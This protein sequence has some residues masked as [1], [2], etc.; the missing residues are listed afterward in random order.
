MTK[1]LLG[2]LTPE[3]RELWLKTH[4]PEA[5]IYYE[6]VQGMD[7]TPLEG[8]MY[9]HVELSYAPLEFQMRLSYSFGLTEITKP[10]WPQ[11]RDRFFM[12]SLSVLSWRLLQKGQERIKPTGEP[13]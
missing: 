13:T 3:S 12:E 5:K 11:I 7:G 2:S 10:D 4:P 6:P 9:L 8:Q 1:E